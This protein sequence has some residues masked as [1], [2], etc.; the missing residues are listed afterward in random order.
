MFELVGK[1]VMY[2]VSVMFSII[3]ITWVFEQLSWLMKNICKKHYV[4]KALSVLLMT[5]IYII[6]LGLIVVYWRWLL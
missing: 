1:I 3:I 4:I 2:A 6:I 5:A